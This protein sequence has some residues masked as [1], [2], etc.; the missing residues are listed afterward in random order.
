MDFLAVARHR[1]LLRGRLRHVAARAREQRRQRLEIRPVEHGSSAGWP[2]I[3]R[4]R[5]SSRAAA[6]L[7]VVT[8]PPASTDTTPVAMRSRIVSM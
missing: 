2:T 8:V 5:L 7:I 6:L 1:D 3:V 4:V